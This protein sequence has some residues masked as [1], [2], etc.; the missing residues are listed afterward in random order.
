MVSGVLLIIL[1][2]Q[3]ADK[4]ISGLNFKLIRAFILF[5]FQN[6]FLQGNFQDPYPNKKEL[7]TILEK[8][9]AK[10]LKRLP[11]P[12][13]IPQNEKTYPY[14][15]N[16]NGPLSKCSHYIL[17]QEGQDSGKQLIKYNMEHL[18]AVPVEWLFACLTNCALID[19]EDFVSIPIVGEVTNGEQSC[20]NVDQ[21]DKPPKSRKNALAD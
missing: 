13:Y 15:S 7:V 21:S 5:K 10:V 14:H 6:I 8:G 17:Y 2:F 11:D 9:G 19:L 18:K 16:P 1:L 4:L 20:K 12:E 3:D